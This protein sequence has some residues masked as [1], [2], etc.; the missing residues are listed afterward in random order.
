MGSSA[1]QW[2]TGKCRGIYSL[3]YKSVTGSML[4][5]EALGSFFRTTAAG[6]KVCVS[7]SIGA[8]P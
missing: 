4:G 6:I 8:N 7:V 2:V 5:A 3:D 1:L